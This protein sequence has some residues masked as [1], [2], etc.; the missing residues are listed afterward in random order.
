[1]H[2]RHWIDRFESIDSYRNSASWVVV[3]EVGV[4]VE[5][6]VNIIKDEAYSNVGDYA[7]FAL[8]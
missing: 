6:K 1:M 3:V 2:T 7:C 4:K 5:V 8:N